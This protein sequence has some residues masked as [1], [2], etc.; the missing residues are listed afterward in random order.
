MRILLT[1][2]LAIHLSGCAGLAVGS[3][4]TFESK[5]ETFTLAAERNE[6]DFSPANQVYTQ[7]QVINLWGAPDEEYNEGK[8]SVLSYQDV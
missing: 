1:I 8:C 7:E 5:K 2:L 6:F 3:Y 4:G